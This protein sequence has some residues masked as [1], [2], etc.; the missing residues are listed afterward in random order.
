MAQTAHAQEISDSHLAA[1]RAAI[2]SVG[3]TDEFDLI[4]PRAAQ[5]LKAELIQKNPDMQS[6]IS[7]TVD[8]KTLELAKRRS[9]LERE[10]ALAYAKVFNEQQLKE[11]GEFYSSDTGQKLLEDGPI[12]AREV[13]RAAEIWQRGV[14][15]DL[16]QQVAEVLSKAAPTANLPEGQGTTAN[17]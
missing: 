13:G 8:E 3:A 14:A 12:I 15:R 1:A 7:S 2:D 16:A 4:L 9:D 6:L 10:A 17:Q 11:I 5:A